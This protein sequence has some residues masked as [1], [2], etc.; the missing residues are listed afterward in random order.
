MRTGLLLVEI[1]VSLVLIVTVLLQSG[2]RAGLGVISGG[3]EQLTGNK[4]RGADVVFRKITAIA[5]VL[6]ILIAVILVALQ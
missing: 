4:A 3:A 2:N 1:I 6:F 5:A